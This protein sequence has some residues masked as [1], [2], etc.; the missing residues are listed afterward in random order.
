MLDIRYRSL[1]EAS[2]PRNNNTSYKICRLE[3]KYFFSF[4]S[5]KALEEIVVR[6]WF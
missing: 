3:S 4:W 1:L 5:G 2:S 6:D